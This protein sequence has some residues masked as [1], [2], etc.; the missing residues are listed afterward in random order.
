MKEILR[1]PYPTSPAGKKQWNKDYGM[2]AY[3]KGKHPH[4]RA[5]D[6]RFWHTLTRAAMS[7]AQVRRRPFDNPVVVTFLWNDKLD[8]DN[9]AVMGKMILDALKGKLIADDSRKWVKGVEHY[10]HDEAYIKVIIREIE[11]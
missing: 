3:Y 4:R 2:N 6:A 7:K 5:E 10:W 1:I 8:I 9:H 11:D